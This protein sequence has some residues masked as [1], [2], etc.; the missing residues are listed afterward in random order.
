MHVSVYDIG[1]YNGE[2]E[3]E[4]EKQRNGEAERQRAV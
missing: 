1:E 3:S 4:R 2:K